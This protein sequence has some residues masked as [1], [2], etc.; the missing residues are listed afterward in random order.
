MAYLISD[1]LPGNLPGA[2][3][4]NVSFAEQQPV[5]RPQARNG[6]AGALEAI[7]EIPAAA[8]KTSCRSRDTI[9]ESNCLLIHPK[10][11][12]DQRLA[13]YLKEDS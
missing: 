5:P 2:N 3:L 8:R 12:K 13:F 6:R 9:S 4:D 10:L 11:F 7:S 1:R